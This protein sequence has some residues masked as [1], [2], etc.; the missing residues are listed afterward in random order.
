V[1]GGH[2]LPAALSRSAF[3]L[4]LDAGARLRLGLL[5]RDLGVYET[6]KT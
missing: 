5:G 1:R 2:L 4:G 6:Q 3:L